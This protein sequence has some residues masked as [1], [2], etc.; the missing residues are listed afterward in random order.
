MQK[1]NSFEQTQ[2]LNS[3]RVR[4]FPLVPIASCIGSAVPFQIGHIAR[5][6]QNLG[7]RKRL[8]FEIAKMHRLWAI[9]KQNSE[10]CVL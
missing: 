7:N 8:L 5:T 2:S 10:Y 9:A 1:K 6:V 3:F 4:Q